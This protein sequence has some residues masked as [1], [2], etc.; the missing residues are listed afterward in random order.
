MPDDCDACPFGD[1]D[2]D[3]VCDDV[4]NCPVV[5]S[6]DQ[7]DTDGDGIGDVCDSCVVGDAD[8]DNICDD[9]DSCTPATA[10]T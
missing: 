10:Y 1:G 2:G 8:F 7:T 4:D 3:G 5:P 6:P 9:V